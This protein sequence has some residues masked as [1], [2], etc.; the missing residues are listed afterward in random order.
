MKLQFKW[1]VAAVVVVACGAAA[2]LVANQ[3]GAAVQVVAVAKTDIVQSVVAT[4]RLNAQ[5]RI[6]IGAEVTATVLEVRVREGDR[7]RAGQLLVRLQDAEASAALVQARGALLEAQTR[8]LQQS[9]VTA[10]VATQALLHA[11]AALRV[12]E[13]EYHRAQDLVA[14]GFYAQQKQ[15]DARRA[16]DVA[17]SAMESAR[18]Q[19]ASNQGQGVEP[20]LAASRVAQAQAAVD[21]ATARLAKLNIVSPAEAVVLSRTTEPGGMAQPGRVLLSLATVGALRIDAALDEKHLRLLTPGMGARA[22]ADA[23]P[24][25]AFEAQLSYIA[26]VIDPQRGTVD[27]RLEVAKPPAFLK[28]DMTVSLELI[29]GTHK[30][31]LVLPSVAVRD[32]DRE[33]PW[34]LTLQDGRANRVSVQLGFRGVGSVEILQGLKV[35]DEAIP[36]TEKALPGD[37]VRGIAPVVREKGL[38]VPSFIR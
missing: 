10:P 38:E 9:S 2:L 7:V 30:D 5:A 27:V 33:V 13:L 28:P 36:Q 14:R 21:A 26:P 3:R 24:G 18:L 1:A 34:V 15:D 37:R 6:D 16:L 12:A 19:S 11:E 20:V 25:Q 23:F 35:G 31:A 29:G 22:V 17:R 32:V 4:G 8:V